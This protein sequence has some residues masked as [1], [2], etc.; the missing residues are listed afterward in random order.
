MENCLCDPEGSAWGVLGVSDAAMKN[1]LK[2]RNAS[3][4]LTPP[5][6]NTALGMMR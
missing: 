5:L 3:D 4:V 1:H 6:L 2:I